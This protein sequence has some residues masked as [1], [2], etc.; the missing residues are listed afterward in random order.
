MSIKL[1]TLLEQRIV[2]LIVEVSIDQ[3]KSQFVDSG[4]IEGKVFD[5]ISKTTTKTAYMTW[6]VKKVV[7]GDIK[8]EDVYKFKEYFDIFNR[9]KRKYPSPDINA[10]GK[11]IPIANFLKAT[12][13]IKREVENDPSKDKG[14]SRKKENK[15]N[16]FVIG[17]VDGSIC[18]CWRP[19][20][21]YGVWLLMM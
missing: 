17:N 6:L 15:Y 2:D 20:S 10:Y 9:H 11:K 13:E 14:V 19:R 18:A 7:D 3:L 21:C 5:E 16:K 1:T 8:G 12:A 4:K